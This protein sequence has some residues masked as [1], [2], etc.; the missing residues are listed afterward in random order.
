MTRRP[1]RDERQAE[2]FC[3]PEPP[4]TPVKRARRPTWP[5]KE[6]PAPDPAPDLPSEEVAARLTPVE[7]DDLVRVLSD[8]KLAHLVMAAT[9]DLK[10]RLARSGIQ[11]RSRPM[12]KGVSDLERVVQQVANEFREAAPTDEW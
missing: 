12:R 5:P 9:R 11:R 8:E 4:P 1:A 3:L 7:L 10:R 2:L 6:E